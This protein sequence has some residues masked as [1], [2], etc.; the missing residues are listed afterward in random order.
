[1]KKTLALQPGQDHLE[2]V[3]R[4]KNLVLALSEFIWNAVDADATHV[5]VDLQRNALDTIERITVTDNGTGIDPTRAET[6]FES[7]GDSWKKRARRTPGNRAI[8]GREG[9]GRLRF[10]ALAEKATWTSYSRVEGELVGRRIELDAQRL[11]RAEVTD[12][13]VRDDTSTGTQ[14][15]LDNLVDTI[16]NLATQDARLELTCTFSP[17]LRQYPGVTIVYDGAEL[18]AASAIDDEH[19][20]GTLRLVADDQVIPV[21]LGVVEWTTTQGNRAI[22]FGGEEG[23]V[24]GTQAANVTAPGFNF[25]AYAYSPYFQDIASKNLIEFDELGDSKFLGPVRLCH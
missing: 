11:T 17:Y 18:D 8:H 25:S 15:V 2:K 4:S 20:F 9:Q 16:G 5:A 14:V 7:V 12:A 3:G 6:V 19:D 13:V 21:R 22:H 24:L 1:M 10:F 23:V